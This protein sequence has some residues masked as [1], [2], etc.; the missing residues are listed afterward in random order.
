M[1]DA[2]LKKLGAILTIFVF[3]LFLYSCK[4]VLL[5]DPSDYE[6]ITDD[7]QSQTSEGDKEIDIWDALGIIGDFIGFFF[8]LMFFQMGALAWY[9]NI[10]LIPLYAIM[11]FGFWGLIVS[12]ILDIADIVIPF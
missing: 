10:F 4:A 12:F 9:L 2:N 3:L 1:A 5:S 7:I 8:G 11:L 6:S